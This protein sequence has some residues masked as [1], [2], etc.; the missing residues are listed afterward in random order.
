MDRVNT[1]PKAGDAPLAVF[2]NDPSTPADDSA[3][4]QSGQLRFEKD[5][6]FQD[7]RVAKGS[8]LF[9]ATDDLEILASVYYQNIDYNDTNTWWRG[10]SDQDSGIYRQGN[11]AAPAEQ[12]PLH[13]ARA[14]GQ[15][16]SRAV[17]LVSNTS[18]FDR[19][20]RAL[21]DY[22]AF[23]SALWARFWTFPVG[24]AAPTTQ[25]NTQKGWTQEMRL[26]GGESD[27]SAEVGGRCLLS[28]V[29]P[30]K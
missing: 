18:Y 24:M 3:R 15:L 26:E 1:D 6:N 21:N 16:E 30:G 14:D 8:L 29:P 11:A 12:R 23:E 20:Q 5:A 2:N 17:R 27:S 4:A 7:S 13:A 9:A 28:E 10:I 22:T 19:N 25:I